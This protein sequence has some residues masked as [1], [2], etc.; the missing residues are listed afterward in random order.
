MCDKHLKT[1]KLNAREVASIFQIQYDS[2]KGINALCYIKRTHW[3][4]NIFVFV[5]YIASEWQT[6]LMFSQIFT[7]DTLHVL[8]NI[9]KQMNDT[10][11][12]NLRIGKYA[13]Y[14]Y[15]SKQVPNMWY[16]VDLAPLS[17][18]SKYTEY[19][20]ESSGHR[21]ASSPTLKITRS[22]I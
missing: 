9:V 10:T 19:L 3:V 8:Q 16:T 18:C 22:N 12:H 4:N 7:Q 11:Q 5:L 21:E 2:I 1:L 6:H 14:Y 17:P 13:W 20:Q 15:N